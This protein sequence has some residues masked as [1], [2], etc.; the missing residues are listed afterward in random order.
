VQNLRTFEREYRA[1]LKSY[2]EDQLAALEGQG[3]GGVL[4]SREGDTAAPADGEPASGPGG[5][6]E[7]H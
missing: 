1:E 7:S 3:T 6:V 4:G 2:F 5:S